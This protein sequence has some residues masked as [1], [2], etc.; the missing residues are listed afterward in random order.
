[1]RGKDSTTA[2]HVCCTQITLLFK[3]W[4]TKIFSPF[5]TFFSFSFKLRKVLDHIIIERRLPSSVHKNFELGTTAFSTSFPPEKCGFLALWQCHLSVIWQ[6][7]LF[8]LVK[9]REIGKASVWPLCHRSS[10]PDWASGDHRVDFPAPGWDQSSLHHP[11]QMSATHIF[12]QTTGN[13]TEIQWST[14]PKTTINLK[15]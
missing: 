3:K 1:M 7:F 2:L 5:L 12:S 10:G 6:G 11:W 13:G 8:Y 9:Y 15:M 4:K 14:P